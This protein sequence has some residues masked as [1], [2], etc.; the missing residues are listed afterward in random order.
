MGVVVGVVVGYFG[1]VLG[2][3]SMRYSQ[4]DLDLKV[5]IYS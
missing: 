2:L 4:Q 3:K 5:A 1:T